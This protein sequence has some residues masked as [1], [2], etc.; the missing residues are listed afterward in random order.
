MTQ[1]QLAE[2]I[3]LTGNYI[4]RLEMAVK[5]PSVSTLLAIDDALELDVSELLSSGKKHAWVDSAQEIGRIMQ[6]LGKEDSQFVLD[7]FIA[8]VSHMKSIRRPPDE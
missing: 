4:A 5:T 8:T 1:E 3:G 6:S 2:R 7:Q